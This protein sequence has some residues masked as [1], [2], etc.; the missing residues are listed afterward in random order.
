M[1]AALIRFLPPA[2]GLFAAIVTCS[3]ASAQLL[4]LEHY[5]TPPKVEYSAEVTMT[6][7]GDAAASGG[8]EEIKGK[9]IRAH[10][11]ERREMTVE[12]DLEIL[13][14]RLD[15]KL[16]WSISPEEKLYV[17]SS[18]DEALG[19]TPAADGKLREPEVNLK[20]IGI[21]TIDGVQATKQK[22]VG[23]DVDGSPIDGVVWVSE[24]GIVL[25]VDSNV[26][27]EDGQHHT[28]R[29]ELHNLRIGPQDP[30]LFEIP[31]DYK[32]VTQ[33]HLGFDMPSP[34]GPTI[35]L[36]RL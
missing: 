12:G 7:L 19:R 1:E 3:P 28:V 26:V 5:L 14:I 10:E 27:D 4:G 35:R 20:T 6:Y 33:S 24:Q 34:A 17:E 8:D 16:V 25:R 13:I 2:A 30:K 21:E 11:K 32:R 18:L 22:I 9:V 31:A 15:R 23:K 36:A 29:M